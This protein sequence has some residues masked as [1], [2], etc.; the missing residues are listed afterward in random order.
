MGHPKT[1][2]PTEIRGK[3]K[4]PKK[5]MKVRNLTFKI[6]INKT[7]D[8]LGI[9]VLKD[10]RDSESFEDSLEFG[11]Y[12]SISE[13]EMSETV[14]RLIYSIVKKQKR[15]GQYSVPMQHPLT[16]NLQ[17]TIEDVR[18]TTTA[19][20]FQDV[21]LEQRK[22]LI[23]MYTLNVAPNDF[24]QEALL[25]AL[26]HI[27]AD[28]DSILKHPASPKLLT[29]LA[30]VFATATLRNEIRTQRK[31]MLS[32]ITAK[33][34]D[35]R[36]LL[37]LD[38]LND[39][40]WSSRAYWNAFLTKL[41]YERQKQSL[42]AHLSIHNDEFRLLEQ[43]SYLRGLAPANFQLPRNIVVNS[44]FSVFDATY[45]KDPEWTSRNMTASEASNYREKASV[46]ENEQAR[47]LMLKRKIRDK[48]A[49]C[50]QTSRFR[51]STFLFFEEEKITQT[52]NTVE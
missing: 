16:M 13:S 22:N 3:F 26:Q 51:S 1:E 30:R 21:F 37:K 45:Q 24:D 6:D 42:E 14:N 23:N 8:F 5:G 20:R 43:L 2:K 29:L 17:E 39:S 41:K 52:T 34:R 31:K 38:I 25:N 15:G 35:V 12:N 18:P 48:I 44:L 7:D 50:K 10:I 33:K 46:K 4:K 11:L 32:I 19:A 28:I 36:K 47:K 27:W 40:Q 9:I 49:A